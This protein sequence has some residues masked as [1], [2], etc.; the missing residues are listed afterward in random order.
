MVSFQDKG[1]KSATVR[2][3]NLMNLNARNIVVPI[4]YSRGN[5]HLNN[6]YLITEI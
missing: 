4:S 3:S 5:V 6:L 1:F 2:E